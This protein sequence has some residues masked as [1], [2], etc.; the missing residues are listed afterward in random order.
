MC[1]IDL[2]I[3]QHLKRITY[4]ALYGGIPIYQLQG[5]S[6]PHKNKD[7]VAYIKERCN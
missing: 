1:Y 6:L 5:E 3:A 7:V 4:L 2:L